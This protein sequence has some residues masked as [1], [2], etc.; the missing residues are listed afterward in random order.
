MTDDDRD[1]HEYFRAVRREEEAGVPPI[2]M[3]GRTAREQGG[4]RLYG[5][6]AAGATCLAAS[7][8]AAVW[9]LPGVRVSQEGPRQQAAA[10]ITS[11]KPAT[12]FLLDTPGRELLE[13][14]PEIGE[15][16]GAVNAPGNGESHRPLEEQR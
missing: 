16:R 10:S 1:L 11:W 9:L 4:R 12:D 7:I 2:Q 3:L 8:A 5:K 14:V 6:L 15:W 13:G